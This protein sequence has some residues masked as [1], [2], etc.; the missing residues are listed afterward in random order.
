[1]LKLKQ[2]ELLNIAEMAG[3]IGCSVNTLYYRIYSGAFPAPQTVFGRRNYYSK[4]EVA[5]IM[6]DFCEEE[7]K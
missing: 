6:R 5:V 2:N 1:M 3:R 7:E 4:E